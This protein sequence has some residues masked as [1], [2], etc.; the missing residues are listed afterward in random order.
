MMD[1]NKLPL[2]LLLQQNQLIKMVP[3]LL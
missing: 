2:M 3:H 1:K